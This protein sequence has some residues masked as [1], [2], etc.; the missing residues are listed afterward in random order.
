MTSETIIHELF[1]DNPHQLIDRIID[2][3]HDIAAVRRAF[4]LWPDATISCEYSYKPETAGGY[5]TAC[6]VLGAGIPQERADAF[7][8]F[9]AASYDSDI[10][11]LLSEAFTSAFGD[12]DEGCNAF[13]KTPIC[14][15]LGELQV[16]HDRALNPKRLTH[17]YQFF[18]REFYFF[19]DKHG[20]SEQR[21]RFSKIE[22]E[23]VQ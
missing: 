15:D 7:N 22:P 21:T 11:S 5:E 2:R 20:T 19:I 12:D 10:T 17:A 16:K 8:E 3:W 18:V 9:Y 13:L 14:V 6:C 23:P 1:I 4:G